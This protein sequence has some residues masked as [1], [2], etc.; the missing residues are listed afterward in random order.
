MRSGFGNSQALQMILIRV[1]LC[2]SEG[3]L[4]ATFPVTVSLNVSVCLLWLYLNASM[5]RSV[6]RLRN[7]LRL[8]W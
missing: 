3:I 5:Q 6:N 2:L 4:V 8:S 7:H 1:R